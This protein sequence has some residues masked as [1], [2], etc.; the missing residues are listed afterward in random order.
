MNVIIGIFINWLVSSIIF[1]ISAYRMA[2]EN[3]ASSCS[4]V[5][6]LLYSLPDLFESVP[7]G[8]QIG[9]E[10]TY[11]S[12]LRALEKTFGTKALYHP[13]KNK[14]FA[15]SISLT[16]RCRRLLA[17]V[18]ALIGPAEK[19]S[20]LFRLPHRIPKGKITP[21]I[22]ASQL[23]IDFIVQVLALKLDF[24]PGEPW[25]LPEKLYDALVHTFRELASSLDHLDTAVHKGGKTIEI[26]IRCLFDAEK[27]VENLI[28]LAYQLLDD[29]DHLPADEQQ[30]PVPLNNVEILLVYISI[31]MFQQIKS[32]IYASSSAF[33]F[34]DETAISQAQDAATAEDFLSQLDHGAETLIGMLMELSISHTA[35]VVTDPDLVNEQTS[36]SD[37]D[38]HSEDTQLISKRAASSPASNRNDASETLQKAKEW[39]KRLSV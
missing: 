38:P 22:D 39:L 34:T 25:K 13:F 5:G 9:G 21:S 12:A 8:S 4:A 29:L 32:V 17:D 35:H 30:N 3:Y 6:T 19:E 10:V 20:L 14:D 1:P 37:F 27:S 18:S 24:F 2:K 15:A 36:A 23:L 26:A 11:F 33:M 16:N 28:K 7:D 31:S